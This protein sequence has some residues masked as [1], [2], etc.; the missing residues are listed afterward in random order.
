MAGNKKNRNKYEGP[1][2]RHRQKV[3]TEVVGSRLSSNDAAEIK[4]KSRWL[5]KMID[6]QTTD[7]KV[8]PKTGEVLGPSKRQQKEIFSK[9]FKVNWSEQ[10]MTKE[11]RRVLTDIL[12]P[13]GTAYQSVWD[14]GFRSE[15]QQA[16]PAFEEGPTVML[17]AMQNALGGRG[18][19]SANES[20][21]LLN[22][23]SSQRR[24]LRPFSRHLDF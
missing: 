11:G 13:P 7:P 15:I 9:A 24:T 10:A 16:L 5:Q 17:K 21:V 1:V 14:K 3:A 8:D 19:R 23:I 12:A 20:S 4:V 6:L 18:G 22:F 2:H